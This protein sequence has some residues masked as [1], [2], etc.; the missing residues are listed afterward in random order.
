[1]VREEEEEVI[2]AWREHK[3][4]K[5]EEKREGRSSWVSCLQVA[6]LLLIVLLQKTV[7]Y[8]PTAHTF[9]YRGI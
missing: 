4:A 2:L 7:S 1:M 3:A 6:S 5:E 9:L 8:W